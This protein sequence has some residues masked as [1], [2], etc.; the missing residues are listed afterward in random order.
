MLWCDFASSL[1]LSH[2]F[3]FVH[4]GVFC[5]ALSSV[6]APC[7]LCFNKMMVNVLSFFPKQLVKKKK[8]NHREKQRN[9]VFHK[10]IFEN[11]ISI[12]DESYSLGN[13]ASLC[14]IW[15]TVAGEQTVAGWV[16][17]NQNPALVFVGSRIFFGL[18]FTRVVKLQWRLFLQTF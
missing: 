1:L 10:I 6:K 13:E 16:M 9:T 14:I 8:K 11:N 17:S 3:L 4:I 15:R 5:I 12:D 18:F 7:Y 2:L